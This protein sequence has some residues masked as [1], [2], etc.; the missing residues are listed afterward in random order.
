ML[1]FGPLPNV[2]PFSP[3]RPAVA[4][5]AACQRSYPEHRG[6]SVQEWLV[7]HRAFECP[8]EKRRL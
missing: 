5:C 1:A 6:A 7:M 4:W 3:L 8:A 2:F